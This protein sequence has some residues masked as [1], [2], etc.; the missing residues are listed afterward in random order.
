G[1]ALADRPRFWPR[2]AGGD[3]GL[4][5]LGPR[6][7]PAWDAAATYRSIW[8]RRRVVNGVSGYD[9]PHYA[10]LQFGLNDHDPAVLQALASLGAYDIVVNS[11]ADRDGQLARYALTAP[12]V[13]AL[14]GDGTRLAFRVPEAANPD[15]T[16]GAAL[17]IA[18]ARAYLHD[19]SPMIDGRLETE[20]GDGPQ[21]PGQWVLVD[22][23]SVHEVGG[24]THA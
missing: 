1:F 20:W 12:G 4:P 15:V 23:G 19:G 6:V 17:P 16:L 10:P 3:Q 5:I 18:G 8:H 14:A 11:A 21:H 2:V 13:Q 22:L 7:G 24:V 9:P